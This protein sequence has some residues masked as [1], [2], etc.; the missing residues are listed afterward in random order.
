VEDIED[1]QRRLSASDSLLVRF[2]VSR[3]GRMEAVHV[4]P[5]QIVYLEQT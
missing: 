5:F 1:V 3:A 2:E 4:N